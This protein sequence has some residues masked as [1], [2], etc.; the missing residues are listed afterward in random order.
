MRGQFSWRSRSGRGLLAIAYAAVTTACGRVGELPVAASVSYSREQIFDGVVFGLGPVGDRLARAWGSGDFTDYHRSVQ[1]DHARVLKVVEGLRNRIV[2]HDP[3]FLDRF[4]QAVTSG[5]QLRVQ[6]AIRE[7]PAVLRE[8]VREEYDLSEQQ[9]V[10]LERDAPGQDRAGKA[11]GRLGTLTVHTDVAATNEVNVAWWVTHVVALYG[12][13]AVA[14]ALA[15]VLG[16]VLPLNVP[17]VQADVDST[18]GE[19]FVDTISGEL[20]S[21]AV[22]WRQ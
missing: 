9:M 7:I 10:D 19:M 14:Y 22:S 13:L 12:Y 17:A 15:G 18:A 4:A 6:G 5:N 16:L 20:G 3:S 8:A 21:G 2:E 1:E 11:L